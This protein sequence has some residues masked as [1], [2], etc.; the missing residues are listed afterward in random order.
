[1]NRRALVQIIC[2]FIVLL[3]SMTVVTKYT[4]DPANHRAT[5]EAL[6]GKKAS[7]LKMTATSAATATALAAIPGDATTPIANKL[8]DLSS[9][10]L[11]ILMVI[12]LEKYLVTLTGYAAFFV[13]IP[14]GC[15]LFAAGIGSRK[16]FLKTAAVKT[17]VFGLV[18]YFIIP[19]SIHVSNMIEQTY[20]VT[21]EDTIDSAQEIT[22]TIHDSSDQD[23]N[24][25]EKALDKIKNGISGLVEKGEMLLNRF[26]EMIAVMLVINCAIPV[27]VLLSAVWLIKIVFGVSV[28][29][30]QT[31]PDKKKSKEN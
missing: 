20:E 30:P 19:L 8:A 21:M 14:L 3:L 22:D 15:V 5:I 23:G 24:I 28:K 29:I 11:I 1:M 16:Q 13:L 26:V 6:D 9:Y 2:L 27:V 4:V 18:L 31:L 17:A 10:F 12:F 25:I 7:V